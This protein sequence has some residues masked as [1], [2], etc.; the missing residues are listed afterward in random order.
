MVETTRKRYSFSIHPSHLGQVLNNLSFLPLFLLIFINCLN[1]SHFEGLH[2]CFTYFTHV[3]Y[4]L[5]T[6][7][8]HTLHMCFTYFTQVFYI[9]YT[10]ALHTLHTCFTYFTHVLYI[11][12]RRALHTLH[13]CFTY[14]IR[15]L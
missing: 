9:R 8:L 11:L 3:L 7:A 2:R 5:Y 10:H 14:F 12:Y 6:R 4:I 13:A 15:V 1:E